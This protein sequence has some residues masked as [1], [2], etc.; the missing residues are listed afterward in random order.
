MTTA[1]DLK[2]S[3]TILREDTVAQSDPHQER[4]TGAASRAE[5]LSFDD[6]DIDL[7]NFIGP[8]PCLI[9]QTLTMSNANDFF[10]LER[11]ETI[12]DSFL[13]FA[14]TVYLYCTY[15]GIHEGKLSYLRSKQVSNY[16]L[17]RLGKKTG[18]PECM[19]ASKFE[20]SENWLPPGYVIK[21]GGAFK[22]LEVFV[23]GRADVNAKKAPATSDSA[24]RKQPP[25]LER[26]EEKM[27]ASECIYVDNPG[28]VSHVQGE[29][30]RWED[31][32][33]ADVDVESPE[34]PAAVVATG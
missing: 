10:N 17:Y 12:G 9:L 16:N 27:P 13:K 26:R 7:E 1:A 24:T 34:L 32:T 6:D 25:V 29:L 28:K 33:F 15:P 5:V 11:L 8:S 14:I 2:Q 22:G 30:K 19:V 21:Q 4:D 3:S 20:P 18:F 31:M 23:S